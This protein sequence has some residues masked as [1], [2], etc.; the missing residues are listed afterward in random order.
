MMRM[1][2]QI[3]LTVVLFSLVC[4]G[5]AQVRGKRL[6]LKDG[7][8]QIVKE[9]Q[10]SGDRVRFYSTERFDWEEIPTSLVDWAATNKYEQDR[11]AG[12]LEEQKAVAAQD[13]ADRAAEE[14][15]SPTVAPGLRL[16][17]Q[18]GIF[19]FDK[20]DGKPQL[21][22]LVQNGTDINKQMGK[23]ILRAVINPLPTGPRQTVELKGTRARVQSHT[24]SPDI[25]VDINF[26][27]DTDSPATSA[28]S[29]G[30]AAVDDKN[31]VPPNERFK[32]VRLQ[33]KNDVR[34]VSNLKIA[35]T[36]RMKEQQDVVSTNST[37]ISKDWLKLT[38]TKVLEPGEYALIEMLGPKQMNLYVWDF[39]VDPNAP[40]N[41]TAWKPA[42]V[43]QLPTGTEDSPILHP[44]PKK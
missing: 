2:R 38:P 11:A 42:P 22:E 5:H 19:L 9:W 7:S 4:A 12:K 10:V 6:I 41:P 28:T 14:Q 35:L 15:R 29:E 21:V 18:G 40:P 37:P 44:P 17:E 20:L 13:E 26:D 34:I 30:S 31:P 23:N 33:I 8:Y 16:P 32:I 24:V 39:G 25:Y 43:K 3:L 36:G 1:F 27:S